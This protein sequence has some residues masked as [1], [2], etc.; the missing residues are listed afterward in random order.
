MNE[1]YFNCLNCGVPIERRS[2]R[3][4]YCPRCRAERDIASKR[5]AARRSNEKRAELRRA[6]VSLNAPM[7][8]CAGCGVLTVGGHNRKY[9]PACA[10]KRARERMEAANA[11]RYRYTPNKKPQAEEVKRHYTRPRRTG[12][13]F[14]LGGKE[15]SE[16][17]LEA[18]TLG[19]S[20]GEY[21]S[22]C[23]GGTI[24]KKL[25]MQGISREAAGHMIANAKRKKTLAKKKKAS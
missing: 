19:M 9:C 11:G 1:E 4:K 22:A 5:E 16:V 12:L 3:Q 10:K 25:I 14:D 24:E 15:L 20:Y 13:L 8:N 21:T 18:K 6:M 7:I 2:N 17:A 23:F